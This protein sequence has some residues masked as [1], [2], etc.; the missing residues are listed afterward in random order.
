MKLRGCLA[1]VN[2][3]Q[4]YKYKHWRLIFPTTYDGNCCFIKTRLE[5]SRE[6]L[7]AQSNR[8][9][10]FLE[11]PRL[12]R[13]VGHFS[14]QLTNVIYFLITGGTLCFVACS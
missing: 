2:L 14:Y 1:E 7:Q 5:I 9:T 4:L 8:S 10:I 3:L 11:M 6:G 13:R 12:M